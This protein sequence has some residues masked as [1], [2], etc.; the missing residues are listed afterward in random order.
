MESEIEKLQNKQ[1]RE[2]CEKLKEAALALIKYLAENYHPHV[3]SIVTS[4]GIELFEGIC[5]VPKIY[6]FITD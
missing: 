5:S 3:T 6:D 4:T 2:Q 1:A